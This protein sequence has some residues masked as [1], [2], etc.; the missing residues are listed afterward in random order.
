MEHDVKAVISF[1][2]FLNDREVVTKLLSYFEYSYQIIFQ[3]K[4]CIFH[5]N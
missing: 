3:Y 1:H 4:S 5:A 2:F